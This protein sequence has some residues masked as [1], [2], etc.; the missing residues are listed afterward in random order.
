M[1]IVT[2]STDFGTGDYA[3]GLLQGVIFSIAP[4]SKIVDLTHDIPRH[5]ILVGARLLERTLPYFP[6]K[7]VHVMVV[8]P[9]V[10]TERRPIAVQ[11]GSQFFVGPDN[12]LVSLV[13]PKYDSL[14]VHLNRPQYWLDDVSHIFHGRDVFSPAAAYLARGVNI[15]D[16]G[17]QITDPVLLPAAQPVEMPSGIEGSVLHVDHFGN[18]STNVKAPHLASKP[19]S[20]VE[21][22]GMRIERIVNAF[23]DSAAG[24]LVALIDSAGYLSICVVNGS[25]ANR[26]NAKDGD[27]VIIRYA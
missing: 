21:I 16:M 23:G 15:L 19:I 1:T 18:L 6:A 7:T 25:A 24:E 14:V 5:N 12:G 10:G 13:W 27:Q 22:A 4:D 9:G 8:D 2:L 20:A 3:C 11:L 26:L 17:D